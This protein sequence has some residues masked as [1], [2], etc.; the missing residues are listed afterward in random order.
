MSNEIGKGRTLELTQV[1]GDLGPTGFKRAIL[2]PAVGSTLRNITPIEGEEEHGSSG[3]IHTLS[4]GGNPGR[5]Y[6]HVLRRG[7]KG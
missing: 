1:V 5:S 6:G 4:R 2:V 3:K 7:Q